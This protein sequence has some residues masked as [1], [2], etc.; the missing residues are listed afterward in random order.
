MITAITTI[1]LMTF[2]QMIDLS[3]PDPY[4]QFGNSIVY[5]CNHDPEQDFQNSIY[6][7]DNHKK[8]LISY[9]KQGLKKIFRKKDGFIL[10][11]NN[12]LICLATNDFVKKLE[13]I[14][15]EKTKIISLCEIGDS[16]YAAIDNSGKIFILDTE[17]GHYILHTYIKSKYKDCEIVYSKINDKLFVIYDL[18]IICLDFKS[19][20][21]SY[22]NFYQNA[23][24][25]FTLDSSGEYFFVCWTSF[26]MLNNMIELDDFYRPKSVVGV[27]FQVDGSLESY[28][29]YDFIYQLVFLVPV[30][31]NKVH[32]GTIDGAVIRFG[33]SIKDNFG[34]Q[35]I[36]IYKTIKKD[37]E[38]RKVSS[39]II[40]SKDDSV[41][42]INRRFLIR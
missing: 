24:S 15:N 13:F 9:W 20:K 14:N 23:I 18:A 40:E 31:K 6:K 1:S 41:F 28:Q 26:S 29:K 8:K 39:E 4:C 10:L 17:L 42:F 3:N 33:S 2:G 19:K 37:Q 21:I 36:N 11:D 34:T 5:C 30:S 38:F 35:D 16:K 32:F 7:I 27:F 22:S 12:G 25:K